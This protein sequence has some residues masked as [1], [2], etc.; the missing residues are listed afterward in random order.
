MVVPR[1]DRESD[2]CPERELAGDHDQRVRE[3]GVPVAV[4]VQNRACTEEQLSQG[5]DVRGTP[6]KLGSASIGTVP[7]QD[8]SDR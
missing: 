4:E 2:E 8:A 5:L 7:P 1:R 6:K 3:P